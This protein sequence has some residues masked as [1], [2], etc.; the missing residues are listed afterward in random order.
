MT[1][2]EYDMLKESQVNQVFTLSDL[3]NQT[4]RTLLYGYTCDRDTW[5]VYIKDGQIMILVFKGY[6]GSPNGQSLLK[7]IIVDEE[8]QRI[9]ANQDF[10]PNKRLYPESCDFEF[11]MMLYMAGV[12]L[13]FTTWDE[14]RAE[15]LAGKPFQGLTLEDIQKKS[16]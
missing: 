10:V 13:P 14:K 2:A 3:K 8:N 7:T 4:P 9:T 1:Q 15:A 12:D 5:H 6:E 16:A 11:C